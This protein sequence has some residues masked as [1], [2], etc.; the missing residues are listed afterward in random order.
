MFVDIAYHFS[1]AEIKPVKYSFGLTTGSSKLTWLKNNG[2]GVDWVGTK[3]MEKLQV[4]MSR[5]MVEN[6][7]RSR[8]VISRVDGS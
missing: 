7:K 1:S 6:R 3:E 8:V 5:R 4:N 2:V